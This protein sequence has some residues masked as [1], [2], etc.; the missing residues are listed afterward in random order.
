MSFAKDL[1]GQR[2]GKLVVVKR[3]QN[4]KHSKACWHCVCSCGKEVVVTGNALVT[5]NSKSCGCSRTESAKAR[6]II[7]GGTRQNRLY[8]IWRHMKERCYRT[9]DK[10]FKNYGG[11]GISVCDEWHDFLNF[12]KWA[13]CNGYED[14]LTIE[15]LD[16]NGDY[17][18]QNCTW[19]PLKKQASN[20]TTNH[21]IEYNG[22]TH[23]LADWARITG[24][25]QGTLWN[26]V[27]Y[28]WPAEKILT[29]QPTK[30]G[31]KEWNT[32]FGKSTMNT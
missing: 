8:T 11:R 29:T 15:R 1:T 26:R 12:K 30:G 24:I 31:A 6:A 7:P 17:C 2:F 27:N 28:G 4:D 9:M 25:G 13:E 14:N 21:V 22:E 16:V 23:T 5:G 20:K 32:D 19:I 3:A 18:P 10:R